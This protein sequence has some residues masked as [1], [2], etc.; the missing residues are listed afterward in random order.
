MVE[1]KRCSFPKTTVC[2]T[3]PDRKT[4]QTPMT[5]EDEYRMAC[6]DFEVSN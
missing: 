4:C 1:S 5:E 3:C 2:K 6:I